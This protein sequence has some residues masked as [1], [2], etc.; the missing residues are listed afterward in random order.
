MSAIP[1]MT[2]GPALRRVAIT[3]QS[4]MILD[5]RFGGLI[6]Y[7][8]AQGHKVM[9]L[10]PDLTVQNVPDLIKRWE[11]LGVQTAVFPFTAEQRM[12]S[13]FATNRALLAHMRAWRP[14]AVIGMGHRLGVM[15]VNAA[16]RAGAERTLIALSGLAG[17]RHD[18]INLAGLRKALRARHSPL[19]SSAGDVRAALELLGAPTGQARHVPVPAH[20][21][22]GGIDLDQQTA[23]ALPPIGP[24]I[25]NGFVFAM[26]APMHGDQ[27]I[28]AYCEAARI[29]RDRSPQTRF[30]LAAI[31]RHTA[32]KHVRDAIAAAGGAV[33][34]VGYCEDVRGFMTSAHV[35]V[36]VPERDG[37]V[38][39]VQMALGLGRPLIVSAMPDVRDY[40]DESVNGHCVAPGS[41]EA[42]S[43]AMMAILRRKDLIPAMGRASRA[44][45]VRNFDCRVLY[46]QMMAA[47]GMASIASGKAA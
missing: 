32:G 18:Q 28:E 3:S 34:D 10:A 5:D 2:P 41:A 12:W 36:A 30:L 27:G 21:P 26:A 16:A 8:R 42:L 14:H 44:K 37:R 25:G 22:P 43:E 7:L 11:Q 38:M 39:P 40:V 9:C 45:A 4:A 31:D 6:Q 35:I 24:P 19:C 23:A 1:T 47:L 33:E 46:L 13:D 20:V 29:V 17:A 15:S